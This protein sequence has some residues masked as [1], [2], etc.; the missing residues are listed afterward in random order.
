MEWESRGLRSARLLYKEFITR[1]MRICYTGK[2]SLNVLCPRLQPVV[3]TFR[4]VLFVFLA[5]NL[6]YETKFSF[7]DLRSSVCHE[8]I[9]RTT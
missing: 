4:V 8:R 2:G 5:K 7:F 3:N 6:Q 1:G 9:G